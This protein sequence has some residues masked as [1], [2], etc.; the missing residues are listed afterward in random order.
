MVR[1]ALHAF[2][3]IEQRDGGRYAILGEQYATRAAADAMLSLMQRAHPLRRYFVKDAG[4]KI[5][6][7]PGLG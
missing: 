2:C 1:C 6:A 5:A 7:P 3:I 4:Y